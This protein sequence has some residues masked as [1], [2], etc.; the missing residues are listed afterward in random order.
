RCWRSWKRRLAAVELGR[1]KA[2]GAR[3]SLEK[4]LTEDSS[5]EVRGGAAV[6]LGQIGDF[7]SIPAL[8]QAFR[9]DPRPEVREGA[10]YALGIAE[11]PQAA[12]ELIK[13]F[14]KNLS[15]LALRYLEEERVK[16]FGRLREPK[17]NEEY[18]DYL[19]EATAVALG[20]IGSPEAIEELGNSLLHPHFLA[21]ISALEG[22]SLAK[23]FSGRNEIEFWIE[24]TER[25]FSEEQ[26]ETERAVQ[27]YMQDLP[28]SPRERRQLEEATA[29]HSALLIGISILG[30]LKDPSSSPLLLYL[31]ENADV[32]FKV[33]AAKALVEGGDSYSL[34]ALGRGLT[35]PNV[36][37]RV[38][39]LLALA[40]K[41]DP[42]ARSLMTQIMD[43]PPQPGTK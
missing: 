26:A 33:E 37:I 14:R 28:L 1:E 2:E 22:L 5:W 35:H 17:P 13:A 21:N 19:T 3:T 43:N 11:N 29:Q 10:A 16:K 24:K 40:K 6:G 36:Q 4:R 7:R 20:R 23:N 25:K 38:A 42:L 15:G 34:S 32:D 30:R 9:S 8:V 18:E 27:K 39:A 31:L 12:P 41:G